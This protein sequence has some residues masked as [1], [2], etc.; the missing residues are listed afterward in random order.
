MHKKV[1]STTFRLLMSTIVGAAIILVALLI[2]GATSTP[3]DDTSAE[4]VSSQLSLEDDA[5]QDGLRDWQEELWHT[6]PTLSDTDGDGVL[7]GVEVARGHD[8]ARPGPNDSLL[9]YEQVVASSTAEDEERVR[10]FISDYLEEILPEVQETTLVSLIYQNEVNATEFDSRYSVNDVRVDPQSTE[11]ELR[12][13]GED[14]ASTF[15]Q[16]AGVT[17][18]EVNEVDIMEEFFLSRNGKVLDKLEVAE[19]VYADLREDLLQITAPLDLVDIHLDFINSY[20]IISRT[21]GAMREMESKPLRGNFAYQ[22]YLEADL[23]AQVA[24]VTLSQ[25]YREVEIVFPEGSA[26]YIFSMFSATSSSSTLVETRPPET[27][28]Q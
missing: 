5:D 25:I 12:A 16:Y 23:Q 4:I 6:D 28:S 15:A 3:N 17:D 18:S 8:P 14:I 20:D 9:A 1:Q 10:Q 27:L 7:D 2:I 26:A 11:N 21:I 24:Y 22:R 19:V 13:F